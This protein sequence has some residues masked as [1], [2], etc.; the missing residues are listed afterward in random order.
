MSLSDLLSTAYF[1]NTIQAYVFFGLILILGLLF[2][3]LIS[4]YLG[5]IL[6]RL[7]GNSAQKLGVQLSMT[8]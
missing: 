2:K 4:G 3:R 6:Y 8:V 7:L 5:G 1:D